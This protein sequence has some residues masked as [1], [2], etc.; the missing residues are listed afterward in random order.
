MR[1][2]EP[3]IASLLN[4]IGWAAALLISFSVGSA[5]ISGTLVLSFLNEIAEIVIGWTIILLSLLAAA[6][7][8]IERKRI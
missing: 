4:V 2:S 6:L 3:L 5:L 7:A 8:I 1:D